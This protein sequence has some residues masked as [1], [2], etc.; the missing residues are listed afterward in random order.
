[1]RDPV[2]ALQEDFKPICEAVRLSLVVHELTPVQE[3]NVA[4]LAIPQITRVL[5]DL[6]LPLKS[7]FRVLKTGQESKFNPLNAPNDHD[8]RVANR[9]KLSDLLK[10]WESSSSPPFS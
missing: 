4:P 3:G 9:I 8:I 10:R 7:S 6:K 1:M 2:A 5:V